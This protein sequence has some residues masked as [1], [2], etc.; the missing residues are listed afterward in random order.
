[1]K[2]NGNIINV[3]AMFYVVMF[4]I[5]MIFAPSSTEVP[6]Y[7]AYVDQINVYTLGLTISVLCAILL[8]NIRK[9]I[10]ACHEI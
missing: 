6:A 10:K 8:D 7:K 5:T 1:M 2:Y 9:C 3:I 4:I